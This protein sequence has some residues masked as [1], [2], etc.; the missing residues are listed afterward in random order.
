MVRPGATFKRTTE[1]SRPL[2]KAVY[3]ELLPKFFESVLPQHTKSYI[4]DGMHNFYTIQQLPLPNN[5][6]ENEAFQLNERQTFDVKIKQVALIDLSLLNNNN[7]SKE[8]AD[9]RRIALTV[10]DIYFRN[11]YASNG[12]HLTYGQNL[13]DAKNGT[14]VKCFGDYADRHMG[15]ELLF[16][17]FI[18]T[19]KVE[20]G[21]AIVS[22]TTAAA[23][24]TFDG[25]AA[26]FIQVKLGM[27][28][29]NLSDRDWCTIRES[30]RGLQYTV[31]HFGYSRK[32]IA[33]GLSH[34]STDNDVFEWM[35]RTG[36]TEKSHG[37]VSVT[38][39]F[40]RKY[41][42]ELKYGRA[43]PCI[44]SRGDRKFPLELCKIAPQKIPK[45]KLTPQQEG[46]M[47]RNAAQP[48]SRKWEEIQKNVKELVSVHTEVITEF[49][50]DPE[51]VPWKLEAVVLTPP[52]LLYANNQPANVDNGSW[53]LKEH[54]LRTGGLLEKWAVINFSNEN[55][56]NLIHTLQETGRKM[57][58]NVPNCANVIR[59]RY[60]EGRV[61]TVINDNLKVSD[62]RFQLILFSLSGN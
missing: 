38:E 18:S 32:F 21:V 19:R 62:S 4:H 37:K 30:L 6:Y 1:P 28:L 51:L 43:L 14:A 46:M 9:Q 47:V 59:T 55:V 42:K 7:P 12:S 31:D 10:L 39:Y 58:M 20:G 26:E 57:G 61:K 36:T 44:T 25:T 29:D 54:K 41:N 56:D 35:E 17:K 22:D 11:R 33:D 5:R 27:N 40:K 53:N 2:S 16:G 60:N 3:K 8:I 49:K 45:S 34:D 52:K 13:F 50:I 24:V 15:R 48:P 23:F